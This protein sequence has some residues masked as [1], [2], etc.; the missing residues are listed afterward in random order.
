MLEKMWQ[1]TIIYNVNVNFL[2]VIGDVTGLPLCLFI[3]Y[4]ENRKQKH[5][6][7]THDLE[8]RALQ[9][10]TPPG[11]KKTK[12]Y[13]NLLDNFMGPVNFTFLPFLFFLDL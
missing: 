7:T 2:A 9:I 10:R 12:T 8:Y 3:L 5:V 4:L 13:D 6:R 11:N 1:S